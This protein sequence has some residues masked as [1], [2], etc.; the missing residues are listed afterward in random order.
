MSIDTHKPEKLNCGDSNTLSGGE[1]LIHFRA[2]LR[3]D[4]L[5]EDDGSTFRVKFETLRLPF[6]ADAPVGRCWHIGVRTFWVG[7]SPNPPDPETGGKVLWLQM[8]INTVTKTVTLGA[9]IAGV[10]GCIR[11]PQGRLREELRR[12]AGMTLRT[13]AGP[14]SRAARGR[15]PSPPCLRTRRT[16]SSTA[17]PR[18]AGHCQTATR[19]SY[20]AHVFGKITLSP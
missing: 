18:S 10:N 20:I 2:R 9:A 4:G 6:C 5:W 17:T 11:R 13:V 1:G 12:R 7:I 14:R 15:T 3:D 8:S 16:S 19:T